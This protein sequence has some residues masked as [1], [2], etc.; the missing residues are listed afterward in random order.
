MF[1]LHQGLQ[2]RSPFGRMRLYV[3]TSSRF[4]VSL[5]FGRRGLYVCTSSRFA[6]SKGT[7]CLHSIKVHSIVD[8][9]TKGTVF[10]RHQVSRYRRGLCVC[11]P[12][13]FAVSKGTI[14]LQSIKVCSI[15]AV[16]TK[17]T[18]CLQSIKVRSIVAVG[19]YMFT[20]NQGSQYC[21]RR[22]LYVYTQ[23]RFAVSLPFGTIC[24]PSIKV[25]S[26]VA[27]RDYMFELNQGSQY[28][29]RLGLLVQV[30]T[31]SMFAVSLPLGTICLHYIKVRSIVAVRDYMFALHHRNIVTVRNQYFTEP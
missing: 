22:V 28:R 2:Y 23:S 17:G 6:V 26:I 7:I 4:A 18:I 5:R 25:R 13:R 11:T 15:V 9:R 19:D 8:V 16:R 14:C 27:V 10:A 21:C 20:L 3:S 30:Y 12:S 1:A 24:L 31:L 29:C